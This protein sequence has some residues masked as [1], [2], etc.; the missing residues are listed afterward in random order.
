M[1]KDS[2]RGYLHKPGVPYMIFAGVSALLFIAGL[3]VLFAA[4]GPPDPSG[5]DGQGGNPTAPPAPGTATPPPGPGTAAP[6]TAPGTAAALK[7]PAAPE[8][9]GGSPVLPPARALKRIAGPPSPSNVQISPPPVGKP[10]LPGGSPTGAPP[11]PGPPP[12]DGGSAVNSSSPD[13]MAA[14]RRMSFE[15]DLESQFLLGLMAANPA[16]DEDGIAELSGDLKK[17]ASTLYKAGEA[18]VPEA[19]NALG[20]CFTGGRGVVKDL[21][22]SARQFSK[23]AKT[24]FIPAVVNLALA[25]G[26]GSGVDLDYDL[27]LEL[28]EQASQSGSPV[29]WYNLGLAWYNGIGT[30]VNHEEALLCFEKGAAGGVREAYSALGYMYLDLKMPWR[31][32]TKATDNLEKASGL[33]STDAMFALATIYHN[34]DCGS[35]DMEKSMEWLKTAASAGHPL[36]AEMVAGTDDGK[37]AGKVSMP[38]VRSRPPQFSGPASSLHPMP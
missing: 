22:E 29:G 10:M 17:A 18:G 31:D 3:A 11:L 1:L 34:G 8:P 21:H 25:Y 32:C 13:R 37:P 6:P 27:A 33:G 7:P 4:S 12:K 16:L 30:A 36:A 5:T 2:L 23:A 28:F 35:P 9:F 15:G 20:L 14:L 26:N 38:S 19:Q 24:G